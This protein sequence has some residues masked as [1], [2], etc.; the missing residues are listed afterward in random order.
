MAAVLDAMALDSAVLVGHD[1]GGMVAY[2]FAARYPMRARRLVVMDAPLPGIGPW[3]EL[4][5]MP[6]LWH[7]NFVGTV[8]ERLVDGREHI[9]LEGF[10]DYAAD[11]S[12]IDAD[13]R[14]YYAE[15][16]AA[17]G[18]MR[19]AFSQFGAFAQDA[20]DNAQWARTKLRIPVLALGA[21][22]VTASRTTGLGPLVAATLH[23]VADDVSEAI[24]S[25]AGHWLIEEKP[26]ATIAC[27]KWCAL[28]SIVARCVP[29][30][31][32][33][34]RMQIS[35]GPSKITAYHRANHG[36]RLHPLRSARRDPG[37]GSNP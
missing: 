19:A 35:T 25:G 1:I 16:Y 11:P 4:L 28:M 10:W 9:Y 37:R 33:F 27:M 2:A 29:T 15:Q 7:W 5:K 23:Q 13:T 20:R 32:E 26:E 6:A 36:S 17:P 30:L 8:A 12:R 14:A 18:A 21:E 22:P 34:T 3:D 31:R 24:V